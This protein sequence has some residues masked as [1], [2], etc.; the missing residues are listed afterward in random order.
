MPRKGYMTEVKRISDQLQRAFEKDAWHGP[1]VMEV[2]NGVTAQQAA[3]RPVPNAHSIW[4]ITLHVSGWM[5]VLKS[6]VEGKWM[7]EPAEGDWP[8]VDDTSPASWEKTVKLLKTRHAGLQKAISK[9][10]DKKLNKPIAK[11]KSTFYASLHGIIQ[12]DLYH[13]GQ[14]AVLKKGV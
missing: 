14:M 1:A 5:G 7:D 13:A 3:A 8:P 4:E 2:L 6:R 12:H 11:G 9:L 10:S